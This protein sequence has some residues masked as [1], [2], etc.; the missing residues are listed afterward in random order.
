VYAFLQQVGGYILVGVWIV[1]GVLIFHLY[2]LPYELA[3]LRQFSP[4]DGVPLDMYTGGNPF[5]PVSRA[6]FAAL[7]QWQPDAELERMRRDMWRRLGLLALWLFGFPVIVGG[8]GLLV[9][10]VIPH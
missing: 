8:L 4:V 5:H 9:L 7:F 2:F 1:G 6:R 3:Y 10:A